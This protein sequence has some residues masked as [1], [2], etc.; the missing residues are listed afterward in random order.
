MIEDV[1]RELPGIQSCTVDFETGMTEIEHDA[2][3]S[4]DGFRKEIETLGEYRVKTEG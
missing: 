1:A 4:V 3:F 2:T